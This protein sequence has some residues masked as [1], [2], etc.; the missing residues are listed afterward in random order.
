MDV[1]TVL[2]NQWFLLPFG[3]AYW[4]GFI[5]M[6]CVYLFIIISSSAYHTCNSF[7]GYCFGLPPH[8]LHHMDFFYA[9]F[10]IPQ[11]A[12]FI[13]HMPDSWRRFKRFLL[14]VIAFCIFLTLQFFDATLTLQIA[15]AGL[16]FA[17]IAVYWM[18]YFATH[19]GRLPPYRWG[20]F[21]LAIGLT[22]VSVSLFVVQ[23][24]MPSFYWAIHSAWHTLAAFSQYFLLQIWGP[25]PPADKV[26]LERYVPLNRSAATIRSN[27]GDWRPNVETREWMGKLK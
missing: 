14:L 24:S 10:I 5:D 12:L 1:L 21:M 25:P 8:V 19:N 17:F 9:Q 20:Y 27:G 11:T 2:S 15:I 23:M 3:E 7:S 22:S 16:S 6:A 18:W 26:V 13:V 4:R